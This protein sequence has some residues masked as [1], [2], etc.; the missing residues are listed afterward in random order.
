[1]RRYARKEKRV[2]TSPQRARQVLF[3]SLLFLSSFLIA[4]GSIKLA[5]YIRHA[6][7]TKQI[8]QSLREIYYAPTSNI[9]SLEPSAPDTP[10]ADISPSPAPDFSA[11]ILP[12]RSYSD[13]PYAVALDRFSGL[14]KLNPD[15]VGWLCAD[16]LI[17][18]PVVHKDNFA[19]LAK[20]YLGQSNPNGAIFLDEH[21]DLSSR[22]Y[23]YVL[24]GHNMKSGSM[25]GCLRE[26]EKL[27]HFTGHPF[28]SFDTVYETGTY[29]VF[30]VGTVCT[31]E[32]DWR[33]MDFSKLCS[34]YIP[35]RRDMIHKLQ[36]VSSIDCPVDVSAEDQLL[37]L[38]TCSDD[39]DSRRFIAARRIREQEDKSRLM[40]IIA[41]SKESDR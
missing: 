36:I 34:K 20:D 30:A 15:I 18:E 38:V 7:N 25:F 6:R 28:I 17:D 37:L 12:E 32:T 41:R 8:S 1:M 14:R 4:F 13:N 2:Y 39:T 33:Y 9:I 35:Y 11:L 26:Y 24:Y 40:N 16:T 27:P 19:Y 3:L 21:C 29:V 10:K 5:G 31:D 23:T 22:P